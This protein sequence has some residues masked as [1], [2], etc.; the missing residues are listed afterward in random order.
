MLKILWFFLRFFVFW[1]LYFLIDKAIFL[2]VFYQNIKHVPGAEILATFYNAVPI[3]LSMTAYVSAIPLLYLLLYWLSGKPTAGL[4]WLR[5][6]N[7]I[8]IVVFSILSVVNFNIFREWGTKINAKAFGF[9]FS[10]PNEAVASGASSPVFLTLCILFLFIGLSFYLRKILIPLKL[11]IPPASIALKIPVSFLL[12]GLNFLLIR[13][14]VGVSTMNQSTAYFSENALLNQAAVNTE[15]NLISSF[16]A[17]RKVNKN[18]YNVLSSREADS[19]VQD[20][21]AVKKDTSINI[22]TTNRPNVVLIIMESFTADLTKVLGNENGITPEFDSLVHQGVLFSSIYSAGNRTDKGIVGTLAGF[23]SLAAGNMVNFPNKF[24]KIPSISQEFKRNGYQTSFFYGGESEFDNYKAFIRSHGFQKLRDKNDFSK[25]DMNSKW[26]AFDGVVF[27]RQLQELNKTKQ[28]FFSTQMTLTNHEPFEVP[29]A[30]KFGSQDNIAKFKSTAFYTD[31]CIQDFLSKAKQQPW[32]KNTLFIFLADHGHIYPKERYDV[33]IP[34]RY[35]IPLLFYGAVI[36]EEFR[37]KKFNN[38]GSQIDLA[39]TLLKQLKMNTKGFS[40]SKNLLN[41]Y[42][43][44]FAFFSWDNGLGFI[45]NKQCVTFDNV[46]RRILYNNHKDDQ[47][48]TAVTLK[49]G[50]SF[51]QIVYQQ[52]IE[53]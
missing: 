31:S 30:Y 28:P 18:H 42:T 4:K 36:K 53:L 38:I 23:P 15:W 32:Y 45:D 48:Q 24:Q 41:P 20:L 10:A 25:K 29:G 47:L 8:L 40:W 37:G 35:H 49:Q 51:L 14:G 44:P 16:I 21:Y 50:Q 22:L 12:L 34:E 5:I 3:D 27:N 11:E 46:G 9:A 43:K 13:G 7:S 33:F 2:S 26:G 39:S 52:F 1:M 17:S 6:Y 19:I